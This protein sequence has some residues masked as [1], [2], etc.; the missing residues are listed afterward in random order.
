[1]YWTTLLWFLLLCL[2]CA[3][4]VPPSQDGV[5]FFCNDPKL[6]KNQLIAAHRT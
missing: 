3:G 5:R 1:M 2:G 6:T 4:A